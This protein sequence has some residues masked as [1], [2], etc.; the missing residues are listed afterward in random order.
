MLNP[1]IFNLLLNHKSYLFFSKKS[2]IHWVVFVLVFMMMLPQF[3]LA[4]DSDDEESDSTK[5]VRKPIFV[6]HKIGIDVAKF[7]SSSLS[8]NYDAFE[9]QWASY[10]KNNLWTNL[11]FGVG[12]SF[13]ENNFI[14]Y[15]SSN[16]FIRLG[17]D[18]TLFNPEF[19]G[20]YSNS[21]IGLRY[22]VS[23]ISRSSATY[24]IKDSVWGN[25]AGNIE[26][27]NFFAHWIELTGGF[28]LEL[29]KNIFAGI[30]VRFKSFLNPRKFETLPPYYVAGFGKADQNTAFSYNVYIHYGFGKRR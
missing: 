5:K 26:A 30:H 4:Q 2:L 3:A 25:L 14:Q 12:H 8:K 7:L 9:G 17:I 24:F 10:Y 16:Q 22:G 20:D 1:S 6:Y 15:K 29:K 13:V 18:K 21:L 28:S 19:A 27:S 11:E 23:S